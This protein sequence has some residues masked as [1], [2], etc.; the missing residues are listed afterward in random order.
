MFDRIQLPGMIF[1]LASTSTL[2]I[3][4]TK[5]TIQGVPEALSEEMK[6]SVRVPE[7]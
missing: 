3:V 2:A 6:Q 7:H 1:L 4:T 5:P